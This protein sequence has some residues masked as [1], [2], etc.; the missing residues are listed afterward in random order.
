MSRGRQ[1]GSRP[2]RPALEFRRVTEQAVQKLAARSNRMTTLR[3]CR[4][5]SLMQP[6]RFPTTSSLASA[7][8]WTRR[9]RMRGGATRRSAQLLRHGRSWPSAG[10]LGTATGGARAG[11]DRRSGQRESFG[12]DHTP[13]LL[14]L[15][16]V[17]GDRCGPIRPFG[18]LPDCGHYLGRRERPLS[19]MGSISLH[20]PSG[21]L[22]RSAFGRRESVSA[23]ACDPPLDAPLAAEAK[24]R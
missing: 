23:V 7:A 4:P 12:R 9:S 1:C 2:F 20:D 22:R 10:D 15:R 13:R 8:V 18:F 16:P 17:A 11:A 6:T 14:P 5:P 3:C 21:T 19:G 24:Q